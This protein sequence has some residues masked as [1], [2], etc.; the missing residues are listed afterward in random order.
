MSA[1]PLD[2]IEQV[3]VITC[4]RCKTEGFNYDEDISFAGLM[5]E[6]QGWTYEPPRVYCPACNGVPKRF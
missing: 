2:V 1:I 6:K 5:F 3:Y 4:T